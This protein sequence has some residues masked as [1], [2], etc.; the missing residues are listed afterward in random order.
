MDDY[1]SKPINPPELAAVLERAQ[2]ALARVE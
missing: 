2:V 1:I